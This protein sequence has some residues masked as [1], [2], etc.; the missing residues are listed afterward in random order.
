MLNLAKIC[1]ILTKN[2]ITELCKGVHCV[3]L[4]ESFQTHVYL[5]NLASIQPR[6]SP[7]KFAR[8]LAFMQEPA[9]ASQRPP[10][11][12]SAFSSCSRR[13]FWSRSSEGR[14]GGRRHDG[15]SAKFRQNVARFRLYR[16]RFLQE[17]MRFAAF[18]NIYQIIK[19][20]FLKFGKFL[21]ILRHLQNF[22]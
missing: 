2:E 15:R 21:Q 18:S 3:D 17:N 11:S 16:H 12:S 22:C 10:L 1:K 9:S 20:K 7:V 6:T 4:G 8:S 13:S 5:Q 19:L 14:N